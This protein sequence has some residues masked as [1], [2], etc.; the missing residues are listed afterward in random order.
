MNNM[1]TE[2]TKFINKE[3]SKKK[4]KNYLEKFKINDN[5]KRY[6]SF[7]ESF[8]DC[9]GTKNDTI[10]YIR[11]YDDCPKGCTKLREDFHLINYTFYNG[12]T[13]DY[14]LKY[15]FVFLNHNK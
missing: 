11:W 1:N 4:R 8:C 2:Y 5:S 10:Y 14:N 15:D 7:N 3:L 6:L 9:I 13:Y 12:K